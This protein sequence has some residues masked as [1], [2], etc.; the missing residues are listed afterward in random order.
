[1]PPIAANS[2]RCRRAVRWR[3]RGP[4]WSRLLLACSLFLG[5]CARSTPVVDFAPPRPAPHE[6]EPLATAWQVGATLSLS[7]AEAAL[8]GE[9]RSGVDL[10]VAEVNARGG[11]QGR[12]IA[13]VYRDD[14]GSPKE[15]AEAALD[16]V[17]RAH[18]VALIGDV[19]SSRAKA[20][21]VVANQRG[22]PMISPAATNPAVTE[23]GPFVFRACLD[24]RA[25]GAAAARYLHDAGKARVGLLLAAHELYSTGLGAAFREASRRLGLTIVG[26]QSFARGE[27]D[28]RKPLGALAAAGAEVVYAPVTY[29]VV[30]AIARA[31]RDVG[32]RGDQLLG[33]DGW[34]A[35]GLFE[36]GGDLLEGAA[37]TDHWVPD[38][39]W[40][41]SRT[42]VGAFTRRF[43]REPSSLAALGHDA[44][45]LLADALGRARGTEPAAIRLALSETRGLAG[46]T[47]TLSMGAGGEPD[48]AMVVVRIEGRAFRYRAQARP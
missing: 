24:D 11:A 10:A 37:F 31:A 44:V 32:L 18:V 26:E 35:A 4:V 40:P 14:R 16:L 43:G 30:P 47:G 27:G 33:A 48:K 21:A 25:Q 1:M 29:D 12:P 34:S 39:P 20:V 38:A 3:Y 28:L 41:A 6:A 8:G 17:A 46:A 22:V 36:G 42:F 15:A 9:V 2:S 5:A 23:V 13:L 45:A 7:G 19:V